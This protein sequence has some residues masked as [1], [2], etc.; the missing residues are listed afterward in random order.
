LNMA[1]NM[2]NRKIGLAFFSAEMSETQIMMRMIASGAKLNHQKV[3]TALLVDA[4]FAAMSSASSN[5][6]EWDMWIDDTPNIKFAELRNKCRLLKTRGVK[7][8]FI[9]YLTLVQHGDIRTPRYERV[10]E[11]VREMKAMAREL[12]IPV[13]VLS[14][15]NRQAEGQEPS[16][17]ELRQSGEVEEHADMIMLMHRKRDTPEDNETTLYVAKHRNGPTGKVML[18]FEGDYTRFVA[19]RVHGGER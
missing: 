4:D 8:V 5:I 14:Q 16:L 15:L 2:A 19:E 7:I 17:A 10:G 13:I 6:F 3:R 9:D 12:S 18:Y 1:A 11:L